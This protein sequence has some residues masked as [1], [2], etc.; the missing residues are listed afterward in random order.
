MKA[1]ILAAGTG[2]RF[3]EAGWDVPKPLVRLGDR[4]IIQ[5]VLD[6]LF[7]AGVETAEV[8]LNGHPRF[9]PVEAYL[10][11]PSG[12]ADRIRV[13]RITTRS[14]FE[15]FSCLLERMGTPPFLLSTVDS[16]LDPGDLARFLRAGTYPPSCALALAVTDHVRDTKPLWVEFDAA[17]KILRL[18]EGVSER[19]YVTAGA[20]LVLQDLR[21]ATAGG[22]FEALRYFLGHVVQSGRTVHARTFR[23]AL[24]IDDPGDVRAGERILGSKP[25]EKTTEMPL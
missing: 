16:N 13:A 14:S 15:T 11:G 10:K 3:V 7:Q 23:T 19:R 22:E 1:G 6:N 21:G 17:G 20:Y 9:D 4:P 24:D 2:S 18:G 25:A 8:L 12:A 5:H